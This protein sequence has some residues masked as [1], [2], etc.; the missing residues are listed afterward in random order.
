MSGLMSARQPRSNSRR[1]RAAR[2]APSP[3]DTVLPRRAEL[4]A[5]IR[6]AQ[7]INHLAEPAEILE[8]IFQAI[9]QILDNRNLYIALYDQARQYISFPIYTIAGAR[10]NVT[11][12]TLG[13]GL[14]DYVIRTRAPLFFPRALAAATH[15][16]GITPVGT[17]AKC[18]LA[19]PMLVGEQIIGVI[20]VQDYERAGVYTERHRAVLGALAAQAAIALENARLY[21]AIQTEL[22]ARKH[23]EQSLRASETR[24]RALA[25]AAH[26]DI[27]I[28]N[29]EGVVE[30]VN[31]FG[32]RHFQRP[33]Q[34]I[35]GARTSDLF[36]HEIAEHQGVSLRQVFETGKPLYTEAP[37][38][39]PDGPVW[40]G[41]SLAPLFDA[42]GQVRAVLGIARDISERKRAE[43]QV[44]QRADQFA[45]LC[46]IA[47]E[48]SEQHNL[49]ALLETIVERA[50]KLLD[51]PSGGIYLYDPSRGD[52]ELA[53]SLG[54]LAPV[55]ARLKM[56][57]GMAG[58]VAQSRQP[59]IVGDY[60]TWEFRAP[61][62]HNV[63]F[64]SVVEVPMLYGGELIG[65]LV[66]NE[67]RVTDRFTDADTR[68]LALFASQAASAVH[69]ARLLEETRARADQLAALAEITRDLGAETDLDT[70]LQ[71]IVERAMRLLHAP[72][73]AIDLYDAARND[74]ELAV[75]QGPFTRAERRMKMG[76]GVAGKVA[77]TRQP[78]SIENYSAWAGR[79][80]QY[81]GLPI[82]AILAV[83]MLYSGELIGVLGVSEFQN[84]TRRFTQADAHLLAL[85]A[86]QAASA[87]H[88]AQLLQEVSARAQQLALV[89]D[90]GL[91]LNRV[92]DLNVQLEFLLKTAMKALSAE[93]AEFFRVDG[94]HNVVRLEFAL[95]YDAAVLARLRE[96]EFALGEERGLLGWIV[97]NC[98]PLNLSDVSA[99]ARYVRIDPTVQAALWVPVL[100]EN[101]V[102]GV[103]AVLSTRT[104]AF[105][106]QDERLL[107][108]FAN[109]FAVAMEN[110]RTLTQVRQRVQELT[111]VNQVSAVIHQPLALAD[112][113][114]TTL[115]E[116]ARALDA[117]RAGAAVFQDS[118]EY[119]SVIAD[120]SVEPGPSALG[121][122]I[123]VAG[124]LSM[125]YILRERKPLAVADIA[126]DP[127][128]ASIAA[129]LR[130]MGIQSVLL[131]PLLAHDDVIGTIGLDSRRARR[132]FTDAE[133][134]LAQTIA[135]QAAG[136]IERARLFDEIQRRVNELETVNQISSALRAA[137]T[138]DEILPRLLDETLAVLKADGG[139]I[140]LYDAEKDEMRQRLARNLPPMDFPVKPGDGIAGY[141]FATG[142]PYLARDFKTDPRTNPKIRALWGPDT[143]GAIVPL[144]STKEMLGVFNVNVHLPRELTTD[145]V[146]LL[147][148]IA[149]IAGNAIQ[150]TQLFEQT[151]ARA[152][153]LAA[154][155]DLARALAETLD[156]SQIYQRLYDA[157]ARIFPDTATLFIT[158][159][160][161]AR[162]LL[163]CDFAMQDGKPIDAAS[164]PAIALLPPG[165][166][167]QSQVIHTRQP[168]I[169]NDLD[170]KLQ[171]IPAVRVGENG[172]TTQSALYVPMQARGAVVGVLQIQ[173][174]APARYRASDADLLAVLGNTA[175]IAIQ[176]ARLFQE[177]RRRVEHLQALRTIDA[178]IN[179]S[180]DLK[181]TL[182]ILLEQATAFLRV[183][184][185]CVL[186]LEAN[187]QIL[188][189]AAG[190]GF[191]GNSVALACLR[192][193]ESLAGRA[194]RE[195]RVVLAP[196]LAESEPAA[197]RRR[198]FAEE[199]FA[200]YFAAPLLAKGR[201]KGV[202]EF[203]HRAPLTPDP[204]W[205]QVMQGLAG[206]AAIAIDNAE[207]FGNLQR[208]NI[209]LALSYDA[210]IEGWARALALRGQE[211]QDHSARVVALSLQI[212]RAL[213]MSE[214]QLTHVRRGALLH[215]IGNMGVPDSILLKPG[216]LT[217]VERAHM[218]KHPEY[219][220]EI[221]SSIPF[222]RA[223]LEIP[224]C[225]HERW[226]GTGYPR[227]LRGE[228][229]P[230]AARVFAVVD[231]WDAL[232]AARP[233]RPGWKEPDARAYMRAQAGKAFDP[234]VVEV[235]LNSINPTDHPTEH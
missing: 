172:P 183:D 206:Q 109:Q 101:Q 204:E 153:Q 35:I 203:F 96:L 135:N 79:S 217:D 42:N 7:V 211:A 54:N 41:T 10:R 167:T 20:A 149:E 154:V 103:L 231:V 8:Q 76:E 128:T 198:L 21:G 170:E 147:T 134:E 26:D 200:A 111:L 91:T 67:D 141:V 71:M 194:A 55:G 214:E 165:A 15:R 225:H 107:I 197:L 19:V 192:I 199:G 48:L 179:N 2:P 215:D 159:Y 140:W 146:H 207:L 87:V 112:V 3:K 50:L 72:R 139:S 78:L 37:S 31:E 90:A 38:L 122:K 118:R 176:N 63:P 89:Y 120:Y 155:N 65:V 70:L 1:T 169:V 185:A 235:F 132:V 151:Q 160:D 30:Y 227:G 191:R 219:A 86:G 115:R 202:L 49:P 53:V 43:E 36:P 201:V 142:K 126:T 158:Q 121:E 22:A 196:A 234:R 32:A 182:N 230:L 152:E 177:A 163:Q 75:E 108:L 83:P 94:A 117:D 105:S 205:V 116:L 175:A 102:R 33:A 59:L 5:L 69:N 210:T 224:Y 98:L 9:G 168:L 127:R 85:F 143:G 11:G 57:E 184:A 13:A 226:D 46:D 138:L 106:P 223:A 28:V 44:R 77:A 23:A 123:P 178:A 17:P 173:S 129:L 186:R 171:A 61:Q 221:L 18:F 195:R 104:H 66:V 162:E 16:L 180:L 130:Q 216:A 60:S 68:L 45:A 93:R 136:A 124:N 88:N 92:L 74:L 40:L 187:S 110:A 58:R 174:Y 157:A 52:L 84:E 64:R 212:A 156:L 188:E 233:H 144:R 125:E 119:L 47:L 209:E 131:V 73:G 161:S 220:K 114:N 14:T 29:R 232:C 100:H 164:L 81:E 213:K 97:Q 62:Y 12:R 6:V 99:D 4:D 82:H 166:G 27:F 190:R 113:L 229:I 39:F 150:R 80:H 145:Q 137:P 189:Y 193:G 208:S 56:G 148:T 34:E 218:Q 228:A 51:A 25:E 222:L 95:G 181:L 133:I 24:Y